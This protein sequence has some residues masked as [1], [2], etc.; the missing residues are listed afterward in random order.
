VASKKIKQ[1]K[2]LRNAKKEEKKAAEEKG[3]D[4]MTVDKQ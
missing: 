4:E 3:A 2:D 1:T